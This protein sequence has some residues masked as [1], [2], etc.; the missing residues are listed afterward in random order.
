MASVREHVETLIQL[1]EQGK[2]LEAIQQFYADDATMQE[3]GKPPRV[4]LATLLENERRVLA[5]AR[6]VRVKRAE[7]FVVDGDRA[8]IHWVFE[9]VDFEGRSR[10]IDELAY[11]VWRDGKII[12]ERFFYDPSPSPRPA[13]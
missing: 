3:N 2:F 6:E 1:A 7:S 10:W 12:R 13:S 5:S 9:F 4:G 11:Q 8:A